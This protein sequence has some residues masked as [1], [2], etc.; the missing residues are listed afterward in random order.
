MINEARHF[1]IMAHWGQMYGKKPYLYHLQKV[2]DNVTTFAESWSLSKI[3]NDLQIRRALAW[4]HDVVEDTDVTIEKISQ[5]FDEEIA[6]LVSLLTNLLTYDPDACEFKPDK[7]KTYQRIQ[8]NRHAVFVKLCDRLANVSE[9][10]KND[11]YRKEHSL[12]KEILYKEGE[13]ENL[14]SAIHEQLYG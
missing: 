1:A 2:V 11:K 4:L 8:T 13:F 6:G 3:Q 5:E 9:G 10:E 7:E 12:F 14:W